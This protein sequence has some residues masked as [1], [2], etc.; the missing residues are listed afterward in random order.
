MVT[1]N[2][3]THG[4]MGNQHS[5]MRRFLL[6]RTEDPTGISGVGIVAEGVLFSNMRC[7]L[8]WLSDVGSIG[9][10]D[11]PEEMMEIHG[12]EGATRVLWCQDDDAYEATMNGVDSG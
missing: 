4:V 11:T 12:H 8:H 3:V 7:V 1:E 9:I 6:K 2:T 5:E 10:Y